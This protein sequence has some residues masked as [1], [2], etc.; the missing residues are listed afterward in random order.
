MLY[1]RIFHYILWC[2]TKQIQFIYNLYTIGWK[3]KSNFRTQA[4]LLLPV[5]WIFR[6]G[7][8]IIQICFIYVLL[9]II[10]NKEHLGHVQSLKFK[11]LIRC[12][13]WKKNQYYCVIV[14]TFRFEFCVHDYLHIA[15][16]STFRD[17]RVRKYSRYMSMIWDTGYGCPMMPFFHWNP[18]VLGLGGQIV[19]INFGAFGVFSAEL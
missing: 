18:K 1:C 4:L 5:I 7:E 9:I 3:K 15:T 17:I 14:R 13:N 11:K 10:H 8:L 6:Y 19:Q 2:L 12:C 16:Y